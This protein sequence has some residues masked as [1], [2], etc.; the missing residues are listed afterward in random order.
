MATLGIMKDQ[1]QKF[2]VVTRPL[3]RYL[4]HHYPQD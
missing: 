4:G 2:T 3:E 1:I